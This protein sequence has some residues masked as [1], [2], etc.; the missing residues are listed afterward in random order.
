M[1]GDQPL[2]R[3]ARELAERHGLEVQDE[4]RRTTHDTADD[5]R[6]LIWEVAYEGRPALLKVYDDDVVN[7]EPHTLRAFH[8]ASRST[9]LLAPELY[10][11]ESVSPTKGW[12]V[13][14]KMP[15]DGR[16]FDSPLSPADRERFVDMFCEYRRNFPREPNRRLT[17]AEAQD[18]FH[19]HAFRLMQA[20][21]TASTRELRR[22]YAGEPTVLE[23]DALLPRIAAVTDHLREVFGGRGLYWGHGH[24]KADDLYEYADGERCAIVDFGH[25]K[26]V[27][28]GYEPA[29]AIWWD[30]MVIAPQADYDRWRAEIDEW[31]GR[32]LEAEPELDR[33]T[34]FAALLERSLATVLESIAVEE[35]LAD[36]ERQERLRLHY[37]LID[38]LTVTAGG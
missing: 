17:L 27:P 30:Q 18:A 26:M 21:D 20:V 2:E 23:H 8:E 15:D 1:T 11:G 7:L 24:F 14:E 16:F 25:A 4:L 34:L 37:R 10:L 31:A 6:N 28:P 22:A 38:E 12:L 33:S 13:I 19:F 9:R 5:L 3:W 29:L 32:F 35:D 36:E